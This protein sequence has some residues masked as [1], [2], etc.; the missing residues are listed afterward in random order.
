M[1]SQL[2]SLSRVETEQGT[3]DGRDR[4]TTLAHPRGMGFRVLSRMARA[5]ADPGYIPRH[6]LDAPVD[7][8][9][10]TSFAH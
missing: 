10:R 4:A 7:S 6:R 8:I 1:G 3:R 9:S 5:D 2:M